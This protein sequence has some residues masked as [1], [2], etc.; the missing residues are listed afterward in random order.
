MLSDLKDSLNDRLKSHILGTFTIYLLA[1]N[2][3][4]I[5]FLLSDLEI[6]K[7]I[8]EI[9]FLIDHSSAAGF[10]GPA[11]MTTVT[12]VGTEFLKNFHEKWRISRYLTVQKHEDQTAIKREAE[13]KIGIQNI[14]NINSLQRHID[15]ALRFKSEISQVV[16]IFKERNKEPASYS[17]VKELFKSIDDQCVEITKKCHTMTSIV[18]NFSY[19]I[20]YPNSSKPQKD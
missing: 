18:N 20:N 7:K 9:N 1:W 10:F 2:W 11:I 16:N 13:L 8:E 4:I 19:Q 12:L 5:L 14:T 3:R 17:S 6:Y 15:E